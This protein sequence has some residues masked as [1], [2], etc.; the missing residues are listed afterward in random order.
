MVVQETTQ[1]EEV[2]PTLENTFVKAKDIK[3]T[4]KLKIIVWSKAGLGKTYMGLSSLKEPIWVISTEPESVEPLFIHFPNKDIR[5]V[6]CSRPFAE[7]PTIRKTGKVDTEVATSDPELSLREFEKVTMLLKDIKEGT[8]VL[9]SI[10]DVW[11]W[12]SAWIDINAAKFTSGGQ[13][14]RTEWGRVNSK[15]KTLINRLLSRPVDVIMTAR[16]ENIYN[17]QGK[18]TRATKMSGQKRTEYMPNIIMELVNK[19]KSVIDKKTGAIISTKNE[20]VGII[21]KARGVQETVIDKEVPRPTFE[22]VKAL[23]NEHGAGLD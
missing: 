19:P 20:V 14:M 3:L 21:K 1:V 13:M 8:I 5:I 23:L 16:S 17:D 2:I 22:K 7:A 15:Y 11:E 10:T 4:K 18:E 6:Q 9:D 12:F